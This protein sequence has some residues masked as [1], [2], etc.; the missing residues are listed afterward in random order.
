MSGLPPVIVRLLHEIRSC[1]EHRRRILRKHSIWSRY[2]SGDLRVRTQMILCKNPKSF[3]S[4]RKPKWYQIHYLLDDLY[5]PDDPRHI[6][7]EAHCFR[8]PDGRMGANGLMD[9]K[10]IIIG[11]DF[12]CRQSKKDA[13]CE[14][15]EGRGDM[16]PLEE[17]FQRSTYKPTTEPLTASHL[18]LSRLLM[19]A[20]RKWDLWQQDDFIKATRPK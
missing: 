18:L 10:E 11:D 14:L 4:E 13:A 17:R 1:D 20:Y 8:L 15:C 6:V 16:I 3:D 5:E 12:Y 2:R 19:W 7:L 9:P